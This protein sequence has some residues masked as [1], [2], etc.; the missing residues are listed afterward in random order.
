[1]DGDGNQ[2]T[3]Q[4]LLLLTSVL[5]LGCLDLLVFHT[6]PCHC[7][8]PARRLAQLVPG[9]AGAAACRTEGHRRIGTCSAGGNTAAG[10]VIPCDV[11]VLCWSLL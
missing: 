4:R 10:T 5:C 6:R 7:V 11:Y 8:S 3:D 1:M 2:P 9:A